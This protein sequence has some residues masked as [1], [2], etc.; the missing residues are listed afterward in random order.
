MLD[1]FL[2]RDMDHICVGEPV[3]FYV[4]AV[5][6]RNPKI[7]LD[8]LGIDETVE[9]YETPDIHVGGVTIDTL[10]LDSNIGSISPTSNRTLLKADPP[11]SARFT[12]IPK[13]PG[14]TELR[15]KG[16]IT[17]GQL[18]GLDTYTNDFSNVTKYPVTV[19]PCKFKVTTIS[20]WSGAPYPTVG[21]SD[22][23]EVTADAKGHLTGSAPVN[24][25]ITTPADDPLAA[26]G[27]SVMTAPP[28]QVNWSGEINDHGQLVAKATYTPTT[29]SI[30]IVCF[31]IPG[32]AQDQIIVDPLTIEAPSDGGV[33]AQAHTSPGGSGAG[34]ATIVVI[35]E[36]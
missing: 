18:A 14:S 23:A 8:D 3:D 21:V 12:F 33:F 17:R 30:A 10:V 4:I 13:K 27:S 22:E 35:P 26:C 5:G 2:V 29:A 31:G 32:N 28:S 7:I 16:K 9:Q 15:F 20:S 36:K 24:W 19:I 11:G 1:I 6:R 34:S 25:A